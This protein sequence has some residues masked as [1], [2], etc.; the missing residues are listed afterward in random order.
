MGQNQRH[1]VSL[2]AHWCCI[3]VSTSPP[4]GSNLVP[5]PYQGGALTGELERGRRQW[6]LQLVSADVH[7]SISG[8]TQQPWPLAAALLPRRPCGARTRVLLNESQVSFPAAPTVLTEDWDSRF[9]FYA[10]SATVAT[11]RRR[12]CQVATRHMSAPGFPLPLLSQ[13][14]EPCRTRT[15]VLLNETQVS[16]SNSSKGPTPLVARDSTWPA[17]RTTRHNQPGSLFST[18]Y[19]KAFRVP[20]ANSPGRLWELT[21]DWRSRP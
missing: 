2:Y 18:P 5:P 17:A 9:G 16:F 20:V 21:C 14:R 4:Q 11:P 6:P 15:G 8:T 12:F 19:S 1:S 7:R 13:L 3:C 10:Q